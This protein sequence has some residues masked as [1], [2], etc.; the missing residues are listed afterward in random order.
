VSSGSAPGKL[1]HRLGHY[2]A[3]EWSDEAK[4]YIIND[5]LGIQI[6][7]EEV[8]SHEKI[9]STRGNAQGKFTFTSHDSGD[10]SI[11]LRTKSAAG[12]PSYRISSISA[13]TRAAGFRPRK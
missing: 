7:V 3:E 2:K 10:H 6:T 1:T 4:K 11:C 8:D 9:V 12:I 13:V 5:R